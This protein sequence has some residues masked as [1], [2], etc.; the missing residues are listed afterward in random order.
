MSRGGSCLQATFKEVGWYCGFHL[1][2]LQSQMRSSTVNFRKSRIISGEVG[3]LTEKV[4][5]QSL[6]TAAALDVGLQS[7]QRRE[8]V[9]SE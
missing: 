1:G 9:R 3:A 8:C 2:R 6:D 7:W 4:S 5:P